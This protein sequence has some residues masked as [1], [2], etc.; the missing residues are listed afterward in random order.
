MSARFDTFAAS[1]RE[2]SRR[3]A[4]D[5]STPGLAQ[6]AYL[7]PSW[8]AL[9]G[10]LRENAEAAGADGYSLS[11]AGYGRLGGG[12]AD[13]ANQ[14]TD[15]TN[16]VNAYLSEQTDKRRATE[17]TQRERTAVADMAE[18]A[19]RQAKGAEQD[20]DA[21]DRALQT[22]GQPGREIQQNP[23]G[24]Y[25]TGAPSGASPDQQRAN[26]LKMLPGHLQ[27]IF[28]QQWAK[29][30]AARA[31]TL[32][33]NK[34][35]LGAP[36]AAVV[37]G[38]RVLV[39]AGSDGKTYDMTG[40]PIAGE[41]APEAEKA[42]TP[43]AATAS[44]RG[45]LAYHNRAKQAEET[46]AGLESVIN[47][48]GLAGQAVLNWA[49]NMLQ[50]EENQVYRQ[51]QRAF[52]EARLRKESGAAIPP[53]EFKSDERTYFAQPGDTPTALEKKRQGRAKVLEGLAFSS[54]KAY[55]EFYG[56]PFK[57]AG[58]AAADAGG[59]ITVT[60]PNGGQHAFATQAQA[61]DFKRRAG[62]K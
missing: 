6:A 42:A 32:E 24:S 43:K 19:A 14:T 36:Q 57:K 7:S 20:Q 17:Q 11:G 45:I 34:P 40:Q 8:D 2:R 16:A 58:G 51:A 44:E 3:L 13:S 5:P 28:Q 26:I 62:I 47:D 22:G 1:Q 21:I 46:L 9:Y 31:A 48:K 10:S 38:K 55:D 29:E 18:T 27:P 50:P 41:I 25:E 56:E 49:P 52:T 35:K 59:S 12:V 53:E 4:M 39:R 15:H 23:D 33:A 30:D 37:D 61:D 60:D 54:G